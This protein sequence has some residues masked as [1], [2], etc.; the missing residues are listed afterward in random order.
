MG[1]TGATAAAVLARS[2]GN[3]R[4]RLL[5]G[6]DGSVLHL[7]P[8]DPAPSTDGPSADT[9]VSEVWLATQA[10]LPAAVARLAGLLAPGGHL[11]VLEPERSLGLRGLVGLLTPSSGLHL[12]RDVCGALWASGLRVT[13]ADHRVARGAPRPLRNWLLARACHPPTAP[14]A[15]APGGVSSSIPQEPS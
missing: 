3:E 9:I 4:A 10:D 14:L 2:L 8:G 5:D 7:R 12:D 15:A 1:T 6:A 11:V 13:D